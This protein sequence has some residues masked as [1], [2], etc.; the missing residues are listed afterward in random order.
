MMDDIQFRMLV[1]LDIAKGIG[2]GYQHQ[3]HFAGIKSCSVASSWV[4]TMS[5]ISTAPAQIDRQFP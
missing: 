2:W 3:I 5:T 1:G 4:L